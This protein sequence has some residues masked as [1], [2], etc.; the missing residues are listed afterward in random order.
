MLAGVVG[1]SKAAKKMNKN[2]GKVPKSCRS[3]KKM[4]LAQAQAIMGLNSRWLDRS[5]GFNPKDELDK[6]HFEKMQEITKKKKSW[7]PPK[8]VIY[9]F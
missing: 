8:V 1:V 5:A 3:D 7:V 9:F 2:I 4:D 6:C